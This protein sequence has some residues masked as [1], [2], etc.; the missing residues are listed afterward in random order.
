MKKLNNYFRK[1]KLYE[2]KAIQDFNLGIL[3]QLEYLIE[4]YVQFI[5][6]IFNISS[7]SF[8]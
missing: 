8:L 7:I 4:R 3:L 1:V 5:T 2:D 6:E